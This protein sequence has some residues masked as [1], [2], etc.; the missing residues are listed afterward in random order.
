M[1]MNSLSA[2]WL[3]RPGIEL[4]VYEKALRDPG[5]DWNAFFA[6]AVQAGYS[7]VDLSIDETPG[8]LSRLAWTGPERRTVVAAAE[9]EGSRIAGL[10][11]SAHR[12]IA[13]ASKEPQRRDQALSILLAGI[14]LCVDLGVPVLQIA[15]YFAFYEQPDPQARSRYLAGLAAG[16]N[17]A[18]RRGIQLGI[19]NVDGE[20]VTSISAALEIADR[21]GSPWLQS[22]PDIGN[23]SEQ[24][25]DVVAEL[26]RGQGRMLALHV[27]DTLPGQP[28]RVPMGSGAVPW[29]SAFA[30]LK[31]QNWS[32]RIMVEMWNDNAPDANRAATEAGAFISRKLADAGLPVIPAPGR[33]TT[34]GA[35]G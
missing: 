29:D 21:I 8:R 31:R 15:G 35:T 10:C 23:L 1:A 27:K 25:L 13:L 2:Q 18:A 32:G 5:N 22:Y 30:E 24:G 7:F 17:Y 26:R 34:E 33:Q 28:R 6:S 9:R 16:T 4:G 14:D 3:S 20:D 12:R 11:L 19:E